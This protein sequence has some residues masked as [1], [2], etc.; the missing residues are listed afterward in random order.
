MSVFSDFG[1]TQEA[2]STLILLYSAL[3]AIFLLVVLT[4]FYL[5]GYAIYKMARKSGVKGSWRGFIPFANVSA[6]GDIAEN[7]GK[8]DIKNFLNISY[9]ATIIFS[10]F[11][12]GFSV[13]SFTK[14]LFAADKAVAMQTE[15]NPNIFFEFKMPF[16]FF[17]LSVVFYILYRVAVLIA[18]INIFK[19]FSP[20]SAIAFSVIGF[21]LP[22]TLPFFMYAACKNE[23][24]FFQIK[25]VEEDEEMGFRI[26]NEQ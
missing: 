26:Y 6:F 3:F 4:L 10:V 5:R 2:F 13:V 18:C 7:S 15:L 16:I 9:F 8:R 22:I 17:I 1:I 11:S 25:K 12:Y 20:S 14:L 23:P 24:Q 21:I 19:S